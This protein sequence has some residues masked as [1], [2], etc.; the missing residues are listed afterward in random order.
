M[1]QRYDYHVY[2]VVEYRWIKR[3][4]FKACIWISLFAP[5]IYLIRFHF[6]IPS[7]CQV[8]QETLK[9]WYLCIS[10]VVSFLFFFHSFLAY[11]LSYFRLES[12]WYIHPSPFHRSIS[13][14]FHLFDFKMNVKCSWF[15][16]SCRS[17]Y[18]VHTMLGKTGK[19]LQA[20]SRALISSIMK[21]V[22][23]ELE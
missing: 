14:W 8:S 15:C 2:M 7:F 10:M 3:A 11:T 1:T 12:E 4:L 16:A 19:C 21:S 9:G 18:S 20:Q 23:N 22:W 5:V 6:Y 13:I 17:F